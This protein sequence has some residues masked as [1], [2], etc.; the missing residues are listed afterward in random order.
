MMNLFRWLSLFTALPSLAL[1][2]SLSGSLETNDGRQLSGDI[3]LGK[4]EIEIRSAEGDVHRIPQSEMRSATF[5]EGSGQ[6]I[7]ETE[8]IRNGLR[9]RYYSNIKHEDKPAE[10]IDPVISFDWGESAPIEGVSPNGFSVRWEGEV[11]AP[12]SGKITFEVESDDGS[13]LWI[14]GKKLID[15]WQAQSATTHSGTIE[16]EAGQRY[17]IKLEYYDAWSSA[18][19]RLRWR[20]EGLPRALIPAE[21]LFPLPLNA[22]ST[23]SFTHAVKFRAGS[24]IDGK[25]TVADSKRVHLETANGVIV[26]P[27]PAISYLKFAHSWGS[28]LSGLLDRKP[29]GI[30]FL[31]RDF[32]EGRFIEFKGGVAKMESVLF[33]EQEVPES[34]LRAIKLAERKVK[35]AKIWALSSADS[36]LLI[37][38][39]V[40][41]PD[42]RLKIRDNSGY[43]VTVPAGLIRHLRWLGPRA[44]KAPATT[45]K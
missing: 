3:S 20:A 29:P 34:E 25:I 36:R 5:D 42:G 2:A 41:L 7:E 37:D 44:K 15:H 19:A 24:T 35:P 38:S 11:E 23:K 43:H 9:G 27:A 1:G 4:E 31:N 6:R 21:K 26:I 18:L 45:R 22:P 32:A 17:P 8:T 10:R 39:I 14:D 16:L 28:D 12:V 30:A 40:S 13:R 33:G